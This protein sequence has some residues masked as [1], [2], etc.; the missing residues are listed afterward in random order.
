MGRGRVSAG[1][2]CCCTDAVELPPVG[3][4][5]EEETRNEER[6]DDAE[7][8][9]EPAEATAFRRVREDGAG[10]IVPETGAEL[11]IAVTDAGASGSCFPVAEPVTSLF[12]SS[13]PDVTAFDCNCCCAC[14]GY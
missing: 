13:S 10:A 9:A 2:I 7:A 3:N 4:F 8:T 1:K 5:I 6:D 12:S 14:C 11:A